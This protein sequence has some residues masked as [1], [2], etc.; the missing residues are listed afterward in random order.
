MDALEALHSRISCPS[1][2][3]PGPT[4]EQLDALYRAALRA[5]DHGLLRPWRFLELS[6][7][8]LPRLG[9]LLLDAALAKDPQ[10][11]EDQ[12]RRILGLPLRA[13]CVIVVV[14]TVRPHEK[15]PEIE[16]LMSATCAA[17]NM[18]LAAHAQGLG[19][20]WRTGGP[21]F[22]P[23]VR[24]GLG[25]EAGDQVVGFMYLGTPSGSCKPVPALDPA[26]FVT[27]LWQDEPPLP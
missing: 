7:D 16:Q 23:L 20:M 26:D 4:A 3:E 2:S 18:M 9:Q 27:R 21:A 22:D 25:L 10:L 8:A 15:I 5:P 14:A 6:G 24:D 1:L 12:Q 11:S 17:Q 13:P 19:I